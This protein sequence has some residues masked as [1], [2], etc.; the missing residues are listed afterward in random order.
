MPHLAVL[1]QL[2]SKRPLM[3]SSVG[4]AISSAD[5]RHSFS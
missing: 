1:N 5:A 2:L 4:S 3:S